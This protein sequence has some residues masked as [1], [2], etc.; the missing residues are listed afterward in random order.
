MPAANT[1]KAQTRAS[2]RSAQYERERGLRTVAAWLAEAAGARRS[3]PFTRT[4]APDD[5]ITAAAAPGSRAAPVLAMVRHLAAVDASGPKVGA[6]PVLLVHGATAWRG[7]FFEPHGGIARHLLRHFDVWTLDWRGSKAITDPWANVLRAAA[8]PGLV[9]ATLD[10]VID[11]ELPAAVRLVRRKTGQAPRI[12]GHCIG[13]AV[14]AAAIA[15]GTLSHDDIDRHIV[16]ATIGLFFQGGVDTWLRA[17]ERL[18]TKISDKCWNLSFHS[19]PSWDPDY[20]SVFSTWQRTPYPH[21]QI[22]FCRRISALFGA[23][24]RPN[25]IGYIH[26]DEAVLSGQFG[27]IP[28]TMLNHCARNVR[29]GWFGAAGAH[30]SD[31][32][33]LNAERFRK[34]SLTLITG[35]ENQLWHRDSI[36]RMHTWL[37][38]AKV[39]RVQKR[40]FA[41]YGHQDLWWSPRSSAADGIYDYVTTALSPP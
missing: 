4:K 39:E 10:D 17:Q 30:E 33:D 12:L 26:D 21:C 19:E 13:A 8:P 20:E 36:D 23:P 31:R 3:G 28:L 5:A 25:E 14:S 2:E 11:G 32:S 38:R 18:D 1:F 34:L 35:S 41:R 22:P 16:L 29:R 40:V 37:R 7:T 27:M 9:N 15:R 6:P 24:Y